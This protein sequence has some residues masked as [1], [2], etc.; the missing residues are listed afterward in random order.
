VI[1]I[2]GREFAVARALEALLEQERAEL[3]GATAE[4]IAAL[5]AEK[6]E[7]VRRAAELGRQREDA[8]ART[9]LPAGRRGLELGCERGG[10]AALRQL[11]ALRACAQ[12]VR[13]LNARNGALVDLRLQHTGAALAVLL[14]GGPEAAL[15]YSPD[16]LPR[17]GN[18]SRTRA[19]A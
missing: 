4:R 1:D 10:P 9:G 11:E 3:P 6:T 16:G 17:A 18:V 12:R 5:A 19:T 14:R 8:L 2:I 13:L 7:L 15:V